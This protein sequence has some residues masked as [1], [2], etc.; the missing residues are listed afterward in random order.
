[1]LQST[2][3]QQALLDRI[4]SLENQQDVI[5]K[6]IIKNYSASHKVLPK[7]KSTIFILPVNSEYTTMTEPMGGVQ[8]CCCTIYG[9]KFR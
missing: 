2:A 8:G 7:K 1:M 5:K 3:Y 4:N 9:L 6:I